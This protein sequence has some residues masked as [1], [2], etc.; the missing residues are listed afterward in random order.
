M[1][2]LSII[3]V[4]WNTADLTINCLYS[5]FENVDETKVDV[6]LVDNNSSDDSVERIKKE[7]SQVL[8]IEN[9]VNVGFAKAN[10]QVLRKVKTPFIMLLN[11]DTIVDG[12][13]IDT[14]VNYLKENKEV[15]AVGP[16]L[17]MPNGNLKTLSC[18]YLPSIKTAVNY[19]FGLTRIPMLYRFFQ[20]A[21]FLPMRKYNAPLDIEWLSG[22]CIAVRKEVVDDVG[23]LPEDYFMYAEDMQWCENILK[24]GWK[25][26]F[27]PNAIIWHLMG[28]SSKGQ[29][30]VST[31]WL[32][33][34]RS[35]YFKRSSNRAKSY[36]FSYILYS[37]FLLR[38][39]TLLLLRM[40]GN[41]WAKY[42]CNDFKIYM[43]A[44]IDTIE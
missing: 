28:A 11:S 1:K 16:H 9:E 13:A 5:V 23:F 43:K 33:N 21:I 44:S 38:Y 27:I 22:A 41:R 24:N 7:F 39:S 32:K 14:L 42:K 36:I 18:G 34:L 25:L 40:T 15:G 26:K 10:N 37:G 30:K 12:K 35:Y 3:I 19:S 8:L 20:K 17:P 4:N 31:T 29:N 6:W 2:E